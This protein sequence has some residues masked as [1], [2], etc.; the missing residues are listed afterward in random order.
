MFL[1]T[2]LYTHFMLNFECFL[3]SRVEGK[4]DRLTVAGSPQ[5]GTTPKMVVS[6]NEEGKVMYS[7]LTFNLETNPLDRQCDTRVIV[8]SRPLQIIYDA[9]SI[10]I[11]SNVIKNFIS[12]RNFQLY[13]DVSEGLQN[14]VLCLLLTTRNPENSR[15]QVIL[16]IL[17]IINHFI[18]FAQILLEQTPFGTFITFSFYD[19]KGCMILEVIRILNSF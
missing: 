8:E 1:Q 5:G 16:D 12:L 17:S 6:Q 14:L 19:F 2:Y 3:Y 15:Q 11:R 7:L 18:L 4:I 13:R 10:S 9:V